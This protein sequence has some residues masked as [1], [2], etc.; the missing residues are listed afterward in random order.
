MNASGMS[1]SKGKMDFT[2]ETPS[3]LSLSATRAVPCASALRARAPSTSPHL[4]G[5]EMVLVLKLISLAMCVQDHARQQQA[6][7]GSPKKAA[8]KVRA[9]THTHTHTAAASRL[10][11]RQD[12]CSQSSRLCCVAW[13]PPRSTGAAAQRLP[14]GA[15]RGRG[16]LAA[17]VRQLRVLPGQPPGR[18]RHGVRHL[19]GV[20]GAAR[21]ARK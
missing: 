17:G 16:A 5:C 6:A 15:R 9:G 1:W 21:G 20:R 14:G 2:G 18:A 10:P 19:Q 3:R 8:A 4:A 13:P 11:R 12:T 7:D